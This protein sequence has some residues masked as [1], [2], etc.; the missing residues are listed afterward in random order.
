MLLMAIERQCLSNV[1]PKGE[2]LDSQ[3]IKTRRPLLL[4]SRRPTHAGLSR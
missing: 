2:S 3:E 1:I 4:V